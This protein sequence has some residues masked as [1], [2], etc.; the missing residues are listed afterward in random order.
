M[1]GAGGIVDNVSVEI[2]DFEP[3][4]EK[5][6]DTTITVTKI[7][8]VKYTITDG[9]TTIGPQDSNIF[10]GLAPGTEYTIKVSKHS[11]S[12]GA[13]IKTI[14]GVTS[15]KEAGVAKD[16]EA[17]GKTSTS[18]TINTVEGQE[19]SIDGGKT[20][21][22]GTG[23]PYTFTGLESGKE[24]TVMTRIPETFDTMGSE[25]KEIK[26]TTEKAA[27]VKPGDGSAETSDNTD[28]AGYLAILLAS[29]G[30]GAFAVVSRRRKNE[31]R[32]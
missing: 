18:I 31:N 8:G 1:S 2:D 6:T 30:I 5:V 29:A 21:I 10:T 32:G 12:G 27:A 17:A 4:V 24:Y 9:T 15:K 22:E 13:S 16:P 25:T 3:V 11:G 28:L 20:W 7:E 23:N 26:V 14:T 19:Y